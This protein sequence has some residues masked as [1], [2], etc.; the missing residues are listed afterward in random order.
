[1]APAAEEVAAPGEEKPTE[2]ELVG[3]KEKAEAEAEAEPEAKL[4]AK[5]KTEAKTK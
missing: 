5:P 3:K 1:V 4:E 2:P